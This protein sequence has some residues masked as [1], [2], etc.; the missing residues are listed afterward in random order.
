MFCPPLRSLSLSKGGPP[1][2]PE[3]VEGRPLCMSRSTFGRLQGSPAYFSAM[4]VDPYL[5]Y[6]D[7]LDMPIAMFSKAQ[8]RIM[9]QGLK[10]VEHTPGST[11]EFRT[12]IPLGRAGYDKWKTEVKKRHESII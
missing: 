2:V 3:L 12:R 4:V 11:Y 9:R 7:E 1:T 5:T 6:S 10:K 8:I